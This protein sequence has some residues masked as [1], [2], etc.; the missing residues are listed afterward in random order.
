MAVA[1]YTAEHVIAATPWDVFE[2][3]VD[4]VQQ[5]QWRD[6]FKGPQPIEESAPYTRVSF[7]D[8]IAF[9]LEPGPEGE[10]TLLRAV[11]TRSGNG[12][13]GRF[14]RWM[15]SRKSIQESLEE[16]LKRIESTLLYGD[17]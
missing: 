3:L 7:T 4:P 5:T 6:R 12:L 2:C 1:E 15:T 17:L 11:R 14:G 8:G 16:D 10:G 13:T 9:E